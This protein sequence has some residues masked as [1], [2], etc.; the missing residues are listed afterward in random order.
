MLEPG[1]KHNSPEVLAWDKIGNNLIVGNNDGTLHSS[2]VPE[3]ARLSGPH[4]F[5]ASLM[6]DT[7]PAPGFNDLIV[8]SDGGTLHYFQG[9]RDGKLAR[10]APE[11]TPFHGIDVGVDARPEVV[12]WDGDGVNDLIVGNMDGTLYLVKASHD[13]KAR[14]FLEQNLFHGIDV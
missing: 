13:G 11:Q 3:M 14:T 5:T 4:C 10:A 12:D 8:G 6:L 1:G 2:R 7:D 9:S